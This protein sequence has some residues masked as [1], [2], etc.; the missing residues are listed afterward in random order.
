MT[1][2][3]FF[4]L[5]D[6]YAKG[7]STEE[8]S[9]SFEEYFSK[10][11]AKESPLNTWSLS[12]LDESRL[13]MLNGINT[14]T[15]ASKIRY[16]APKRSL[17]KTTWA[18]A[19]SIALLIVSGLLYV[20][21]LEQ[22]PQVAYIT[23]STTKGQKSTIRLSDGTQVKLNAGSTI[24]YPERFND[25]LR[26]I[27]LKGEAYFDVK[28]NPRKPFV[29]KSYGISTTVL[30]TSFN[31]NAY[32]S[33]AIAVALTSG[34]VK[35]TQTE[36]NRSDI[37]LNPG[38]G[39]FYDALTDEIAIETFDS[40]ALTAWK[41]GIIYMS[42]A[43]YNQVFD[44][45]ARWYGVEFRLENKPDIKWVYSG[46]FKD[47]SLELVLNTIGYSGGFD[48]QILGEVVVIEFTS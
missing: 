40:K 48:Y 4:R 36:G 42:D 16:I 38:E 24:S 35:I 27:T 43:S 28:E 23:K 10:L 5:A 12:K 37:Y 18:V 30:G 2:E 22:E 15:H 8:E 14:R 17:L 21:S 9:R 32:D 1:K 29:V 11:D 26:Q 33:L 45:L 34:K 39:A 41:D 47:M 19:A 3:E 7:V 6:K 13:R 46:E 31:V 25:D 44:K 20:N